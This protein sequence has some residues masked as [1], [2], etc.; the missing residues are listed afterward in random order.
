MNLSRAMEL[1]N[2]NIATSLITIVYSTFLFYIV[3]FAVLG[4]GVILYAMYKIYVEAIYLIILGFYI[5]FPGY[6]FSQI[7]LFSSIIQQG[8]KSFNRLTEKL[9]VG[10]LQALPITLLKSIVFSL[11]MIP[12]IL[13][14][15]FLTLD[16]IIIFLVGVNVLIAMAISEYLFYYPYFL[17]IV[18]Q[19][20]LFESI[21]EGI[22][23]SLSNLFRMS[24]I[25]FP[26][27]LAILIQLV[28][29]LNLIVIFWTPVLHM[30]VV[31]NTLKG[32]SNGSR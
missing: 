16:I 8:K 32:G 30:Y 25:H 22:K 9:I 27:M 19:R 21:V 15:Q 13:A 11:F 20:K 26:Y 23:L 28:P 3:M 14:Y 5:F 2:K 1:A 29:V 17:Y 7:D 10:S 24:I 6:L 12:S 18:L 4:L 31:G